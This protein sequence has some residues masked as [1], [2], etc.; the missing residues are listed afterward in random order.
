MVELIGFY[1]GKRQTCL[2]KLY[3]GRIRSVPTVGNIADNVRPMMRRTRNKPSGLGAAMP[4]LQWANGIG[5]QWVN[6]TVRSYRQGAK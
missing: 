4:I 3:F 2:R 1:F 5:N 6:D